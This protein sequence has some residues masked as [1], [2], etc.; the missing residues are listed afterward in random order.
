[1]NAT[2]SNNYGIERYTASSE[3]DEPTI[4]RQLPKLW[5]AVL[6]FYTAL[7][8]QF[9]KWTYGVFEL[10][11]KQINQALKMFCLIGFLY[12][13]APY[14]HNLFAKEF[15]MHAWRNYCWTCQE[16]PSLYCYLRDSCCCCQK[17]VEILYPR[18][19][20]FH[21][22]HFQMRT[23]LLHPQDTKRHHCLCI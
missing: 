1:M 4:F 20:G 7:E 13:W 10:L 18:K 16:S 21:R 22:L 5:Q 8:Y 15:L 3:Q 19:L 23:R 14:W 12:S 2:N 17:V 11:P 9:H 6:R